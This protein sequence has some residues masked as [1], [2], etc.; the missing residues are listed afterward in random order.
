MRD[1]LYLSE[2]KMRALVPQLPGRWRGRLGLEAG[3]NVGVASMKTTL[4]S[5]TPSSVAFLDAVLKMIEKNKGS[6][7]RTDERVRPGNWIQ[8]EEHLV[9]ADGEV[10][11]RR[12]NPDPADNLVYFIA[13]D[14]W[15]PEAEGPFV[16]VGSAVNM[17]DRWQPPRSESGDPWRSYAD[18]VY[19]YAKRIQKSRDDGATSVRNIAGGDRWLGYGINLMCSHTNRLD[20][21]HAGPIL[22]RGCARVLAVA[23]MTNWKPSLLATPLY[24]EYA[25]GDN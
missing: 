22:L 25:T 1:L 20:A 3:F 15:G 13:P 24:V 6:R 11:R 5:E 19:S 10:G 7:S 2:N 14:R 12:S 17:L 16:L 4:P 9:V 21:F 23:H 8:F 18:S